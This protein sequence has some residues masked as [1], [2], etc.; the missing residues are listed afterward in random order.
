MTNIKKLG[1]ALAPFLFSLLA[2]KLAYSFYEYASYRVPVMASYHK[3]E[4]VFSDKVVLAAT[5]KNKEYKGIIMLKKV[6]EKFV[7]DE[8]VA[9][10][11]ACSVYYWSWRR[12]ISPILLLAIIMQESKF[13]PRAVSSRGAVGLMQVMPFWVA[14]YKHETNKNIDLLNIDNNIEIGSYVLKYYLDN[15]KSIVEALQKYN[16]S[17]LSANSMRYPR[18]VFMY[19]RKFR[20]H[21]LG[22]F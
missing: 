12:N 19:Y 13:D 17:Y 20:R 1:Q 16:A 18:R 7:D 11:I 4:A 2:T 14:V 21:F 9:N 10:E 15:S 22:D 3:H 8:N 6:V 5:N